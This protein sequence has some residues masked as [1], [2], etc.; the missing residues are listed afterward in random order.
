MARKKK[1]TLTRDEVVKALRNSKPRGKVGD[2][3]V[4]QST[5]SQ[6][7]N[8]TSPNDPNLMERKYVI[9]DDPKTPA[10]E[11]QRELWA[12][13]VAE[14]QALSPEEKAEWNRLAGRK[15]GYRGFQLFMS[16]RPTLRRGR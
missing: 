11:R 8:L 7:A 2:I 1:K 3:V 14:W 5:S 13:R 4:F 12:N 10:Q 15:R 9:P 6:F 16:R